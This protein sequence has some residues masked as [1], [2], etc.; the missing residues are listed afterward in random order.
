MKILRNESIKK[1]C[2]FHT[3][4]IIE[5]YIIPENIE[6]LVSLIKSFKL[7][8]QEY[9]IL[10][11]GSNILFSDKVFDI[12]L[13]DMT[14]LQDI[15]VLDNL[16]IAE[17]GASISKVA[18]KAYEH[19]LTGMEALK[20]IP[21]SLGGAVRMNAGAYGSEISDVLKYVDILD[22]NGEIKRLSKEELCLTYRHSIIDEKDYIV[23]RVCLNLE[24]GDKDEILS[25]MK[26]YQN[27]RADKQP[28][29]KYSAGSTFKRPKGYFAG[30]L[31]ED[32]GLKG[33]S[34]GDAEVSRKHAGFIVNNGTASS[35][36]IYELI[37]KVKSE[38]LKKFNVELETEL[39][40]IGDF[41][42]Q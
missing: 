13:I 12:P 29:T 23:I 26:D 42:E 20:G 11:K 24:N 8:K 10:G 25:L 40:I 17:A 7:K 30:K 37:K 19:S 9:F 5:E 2:S 21:G 39:K 14:Y 3:G 16:I 1:H 4:G 36:E 33:Y 35:R 28:L 15:K 38:V 27:R 6:E 31:I 32:A 18:N 22:E 41:S 34:I